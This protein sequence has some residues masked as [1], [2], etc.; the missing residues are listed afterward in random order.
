MT[1]YVL[2]LTLSVLFGT[3]QRIAV[4]HFATHQACQAALDSLAA[5]HGERITGA[6]Y[7]TGAR[8]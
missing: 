2:I 4:I 5:V 3:D 8:P 6:C 7:A 1:P